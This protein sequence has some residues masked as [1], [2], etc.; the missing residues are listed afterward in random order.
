M[1]IE[2]R[3]NRPFDFPKYF[4]DEATRLK[5]DRSLPNIAPIGT[6]LPAA[7]IDETEDGYIVELA[8]PGLNHK[9]FIV[10]LRNDI[11]TIKANA[12]VSNR[13][14]KK[15]RRREFNYRAFHRTFRLPT[16]IDPRSGIE[17]NYENG[18][19]EIVISRAA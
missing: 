6:T 19:L 14:G 2:K 8:V 12:P 13:E 3:K 17:A 7:N 16:D 5:F 11:L 18:I 15:T 4:D 1:Q 10:D 9:D